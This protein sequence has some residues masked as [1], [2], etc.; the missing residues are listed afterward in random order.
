MYTATV[1][2]VY[3]LLFP[4]SGIGRSGAKGEVE[5][6]KCFSFNGHIRSWTKCDIDM[7]V[8]V[9]YDTFIKYFTLKIK[10]YLQQ[11]VGS[12]A[13]DRYL[14]INLRFDYLEQIIVS[15]GHPR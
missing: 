10:F 5:K 11:V 13:K 12:S 14:T 7:P 1:R 6:K 15:N 4:V 3:T 2:S 9:A 8:N